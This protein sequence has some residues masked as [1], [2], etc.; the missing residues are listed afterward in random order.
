MVM[1][2]NLQF[3]I[4]TKYFLADILWEVSLSPSPSAFHDH[5]LKANS[6]WAFGRMWNRITIRKEFT[7]KLSD[8]HFLFSGILALADCY[9]GWQ[10][11]FCAMKWIWTCTTWQKSCMCEDNQWRRMKRREKSPLCWH[12]H[13]EQTEGGGSP[14][15]HNRECQMSK[16]RSCQFTS[17]FVFETII[18]L[19]AI[20]L[21]NKYLTNSCILMLSVRLFI[22]LAH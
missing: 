11:V 14:R 6:I 4:Q 5:C 22:K 2:V 12:L 17:V 10:A 18:L 3:G 19:E 8:S 1:G 13:T 16:S 7:V 15:T 20:P 21:A 9:A